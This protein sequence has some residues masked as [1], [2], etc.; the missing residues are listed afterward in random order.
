MAT[1]TKGPEFLKLKV[2]AYPGGA[3]FDVQFEYGEEGY[4]LGEVSIG[5][6]RFHVEAVEVEVEE[7]KQ[8]IGDK[9]AG[10]MVH[11]YAKNGAYHNRIESWESANDFNTPQLVEYDGR[12]YF[13]HAEPYAA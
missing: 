6:T 2:E 3:G 1:K 13:V 7:E 12:K 9:Y 4:Y 5:G 10:T 11:V 8:Y